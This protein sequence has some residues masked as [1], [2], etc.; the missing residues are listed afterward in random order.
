[1]T[2]YKHTETEPNDVCFF[3]LCQLLLLEFSRDGYNA[4]HVIPNTTAGGAAF[5]WDADFFWQSNY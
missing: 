2:E 5:F 4:H 1:M 3:L